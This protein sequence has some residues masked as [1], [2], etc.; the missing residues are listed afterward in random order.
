MKSLDEQPSSLVLVWIGILMIVLGCLCHWLSSQP[1][2]EFIRP[3]GTG[4]L[5]VGSAVAFTAQLFR[6]LFK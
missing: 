2:Y 6:V 5:I 1:G 3:Y 4:S